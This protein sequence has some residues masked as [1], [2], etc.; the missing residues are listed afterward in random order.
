MAEPI[1]EFHGI[2]GKI[3]LYENRLEI[4]RGGWIASLMHIG[5]G[6]KTVPLDNVSAVDVN[7]GMNGGYIDIVTQGREGVGGTFSAETT[8][9]TIQF[10]DQ[11]QDDVEELHDRIF[12]MQSSESNAS[13][14]DPLERLRRR[15]ADGEID[16]E[17]FEQRRETLTE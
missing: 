13:D 12:E 8:E 14:D 10:M 17:E 15:F 5:Q 2:D 16:K 4:Q 9:Y 11:Q 3:E 7:D 6:D 1:Y